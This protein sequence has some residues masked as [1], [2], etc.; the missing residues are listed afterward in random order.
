MTL[1]ETSGSHLIYRMRPSCFSKKWYKALDEMQKDLQTYLNHYNRK[2][3]HQG[4][5]MNGRTP[6]KAFIDGIEKT[7][8]QETENL[9]KAA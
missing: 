2:R 5:N 3:P 4:R 6:Y 8:K 9:E 7:P 1:K